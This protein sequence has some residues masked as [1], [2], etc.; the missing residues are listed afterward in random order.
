MLLW[1]VDSDFL[2]WLVIF[3]PILTEQE[4]LCCNVLPTAFSAQGIF[5]TKVAAYGTQAGDLI[6][7]MF[8]CSITYNFSIKLFIPQVKDQTGVSNGFWS[9]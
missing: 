4:D 3:H 9:F 7:I 5:F 2:Y 1:I 6:Y 8:P